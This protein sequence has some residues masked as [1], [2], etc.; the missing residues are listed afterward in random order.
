[1]QDI[2]ACMTTGFAPLLHSH[3]RHQSCIS[4]LKVAGLG[5]SGK[6]RSLSVS[7]VFLCVEPRG[8]QPSCF[9]GSRP[10]H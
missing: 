1:M 6:Y 10:Y 9:L 4:A 3:F 7:G 2:V 5:R 8:S